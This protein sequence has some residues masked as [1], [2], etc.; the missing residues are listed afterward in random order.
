MLENS[1]FSLKMR[2]VAQNVVFPTGGKNIPLKLV[3]LGGVFTH[4][5]QNL[6]PFVLSLYPTRDAMSRGKRATGAFHDFGKWVE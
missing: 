3:S 2:T 4:R 5:V 1:L 6:Q